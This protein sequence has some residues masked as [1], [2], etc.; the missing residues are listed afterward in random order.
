MLTA[1]ALL[2]GTLF[3]IL[4]VAVTVP[5]GRHMHAIFEGRRTWLH[6]LLRPVERLVYR[7]CGV[8]EDEEMRWTTYTW[9][10][11]AFTLVGCLVTYA[12]QRLQGFLPLNPQ[13]FGTAM[14]PAGATPMTP[15]LAFNTAVSF[16]TN[17]NWQ[18]YVPESTMSHLTQMLGLAPHNFFSAVTGIAV[19]VVVTRGFTRRSCATV[20]SFWVDLVRCTLYLLVPLSL[21]GAMLLAW[22][23][24]PQS[25]QAS[26]VVRTLEGQ[27]QVIALGPV[28][29]QEAIKM[30]G[31]N[32]GGF[33]NA[34]SAHPFENPTPLSNLLEMLMIFMVPAGLTHFFGRQ[35]QDVRQ[36]WALFA[37]MFVLF[38]AGGVVC[39]GAEQAGNPLVAASGV[40][41]RASSQQAGGNMEGKEVRFGITA[42]A[43]F[44]TVTTDASCG[45]VNCMH[46]SLTPLGGLVTLANIQLGEVVFGGVGSGLYGMLVYA[47][48]A[49][50]IAGLMVGRTPEYLGK[51]I[52]QKEV[53]MA[54]LAVLAM[55]AGILLTTALPLV[56]ALPAGSSWNLDPTGK[57]VGT[58]TQNVA[59]AGPHGFTEILYAFSSA[60]GNN[61]SAFAGLSA[62]TPFYNLAL[63]IAM[64]IG[65]FL[66]VVPVMAMAGS[67]AA[68]RHV[69]PGAGTFPTH[70]GTFV[71]LLVAVVI[72]V[73]ALTFFP[74]LA[75]GPVVEFLQLRH[76]VT[77]AL[78]DPA[79][80]ALSMAWRSCHVA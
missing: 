78:A 36:G 13:H 41:C 59:N 40:D 46:D 44:A 4:L 16:A 26:T 72:V 65:R 2:Q 73:G 62:N 50:F 76:G 19:A 48:L 37:A 12:L 14:A 30:V 1:N 33:F 63:G 80:N 24:V 77:W 38:V 3:C 35:V 34:N 56:I 23:G 32:G 55:S 58:L 79:G 8:R 71:M 52:E 42:S 11:L 28:A 20:G 17:T 43:L 69:P 10:L 68:K 5:L 54:M 31:T 47:V 15:D 51:K 57:D 7:A 25:L 29:S 27:P 67:L 61:G 22:Q 39:T 53:K 74:A 6:P 45:A 75:L 18:S 64:L 9:A 70:S 66:M 60:T 21:V 49:V